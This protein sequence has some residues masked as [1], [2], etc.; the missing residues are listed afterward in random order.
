MD[1]YFTYLEE[2]YPKTDPKSA[3][4]KAIHF[5]LNLKVDLQR[6]LEDGHIELTNNLSLCPTIYYPQLLHTY[7]VFA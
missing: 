3:L 6:C 7:P 5:S 2:I 4:G 1:E